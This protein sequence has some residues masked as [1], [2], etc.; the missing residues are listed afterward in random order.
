MRC[1]KCKTKTLVEVKTTGGVPLDRCKQCK[2]VWSDAGELEA[3]LDSAAQHLDVSA[4]SHLI[5]PPCPR[6]GD[7]MRVFYYPGTY[8]SVDVCPDCRGLWFDAGELNEVK[9]VRRK[10]MREGKLKA[11]SRAP[12]PTGAKASIIDFINNAIADLSQFD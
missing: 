7:A 12:R 3:L 10:L 1:P 4:D 6:C 2:G 8:V 11:G 9:V 5:G